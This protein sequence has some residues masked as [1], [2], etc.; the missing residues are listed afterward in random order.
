[1]AN[2]FGAIEVHRWA[3]EALSRARQS[4]G[5]ELWEAPFSEA[6]LARAERL[7]EENRRPS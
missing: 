5:A 7:I 6:E 3:R 2:E 1:M 4:N